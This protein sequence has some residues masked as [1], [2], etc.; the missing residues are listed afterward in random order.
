MGSIVILIH[1]APASGKLTTARKLA[2]VLTDLGQTP[3]LHNHLT[4]NIAT[5]LFA[6][7]DPRLNVLHRELRLVMLRH[8]LAAQTPEIIMTLVYAEPESVEHV[9]EIADLITRHNAVLLPV[10]LDCPSEQLL[11]RVAM[12]E[13]AAEGKL[14][15]PERLTELLA[16]HHY[17]PIP[18]A[19]TVIF[20]NANQSADVTAE[21]IAKTVPERAHR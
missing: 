17:P 11:Q 3:I 15:S 4:F 19:D 6:I 7:G 20:S 8:A 13:R 1:G 12:P 9:R 10:F 18:G 16:S 5:T 14:Q 21:E 2:E